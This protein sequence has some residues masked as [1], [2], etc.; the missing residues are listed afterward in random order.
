MKVDIANRLSGMRG[1]E[2]VILESNKFKLV[3]REFQDKASSIKLNNGFEIGSKK[4]TVIAGPCA[5][6][7]QKQLFDCVH[8]VKNAGASIIRGGAFKPR[9]SPYSF[10]GMEKKGLKLLSLVGEK[11]GLP[12]VTEV[13][14]PE[15]IDLVA[16]YADILQIGTRNMQNFPLLKKVGKVN[17]PILLKRGMSAT[18]EELLLSAEYIVSNGNS[19]VILCERGIRTFE[20]MTRNTLD[21]SI[22]PLVKNLSHLPII[23]DPSHAT[24]KRELIEPMSKAAVAAGA[25]GIMIEVH[26]N[27]DNA[28]VDGKQSLSLTDFSKL[29]RELIPVAR[30]VGRDV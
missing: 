19:K 20:K 4:I 17:R 27:P 23:V 18:I 3:S 15:D 5:V 6:E 28:L 24:G 26:P 10:Q 16:N 7:N 2:R 14:C 13:M 12:V 21:L 1:I 9:T 29:M 22:V 11:T 8:F 25:D 30:A